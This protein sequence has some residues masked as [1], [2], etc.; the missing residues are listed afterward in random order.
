MPAPSKERAF[1]YIGDSTKSHQNFMQ[2][3]V[4]TLLDILG[5]KG[6]WQRQR[7]Q[8]PLA[9]LQSILAVAEEH[10]AFLGASGR[11][12]YEVVSISDTIA[13]V[14]YPA[15]DK[16]HERDQILEHGI[17]SGLL[18]RYSIIHGIPLRGATSV[19]E[20]SKQGNALIGPAVD[21]VASWYEAVDWIGVITCPSIYLSLDTYNAIDGHKIE[22]VY[23]KYK[24]PLKTKPTE[25][26]A[27]KWPMIWKQSVDELEKFGMKNTKSLGLEARTRNELVDYFLKMGPLSPDIYPKYSNTIEFY[28]YV[29]E[30]LKPTK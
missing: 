23:S 26:L 15:N 29:T 9:N 30:Q 4:I 22:S 12:K 20:F 8:D 2:T 19:G 21:E 25:S 1:L 14:S 7:D 11:H 10:S 3:G 13:L 6:V 5:W 16:R 18:I 24:V 28:K 17:I 27:V